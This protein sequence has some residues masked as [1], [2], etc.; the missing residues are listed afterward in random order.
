[1]AAAAAGAIRDRGKPGEPVM[2]A[3]AAVAME[4]SALLILLLLVCGCCSNQ[5][6]DLRL[7]STVAAAAAADVVHMA[8]P[9]QDVGEFDLLLRDWDWESA[10]GLADADGFLENSKL[11]DPVGL[12]TALI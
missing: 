5:A 1:M 10:A 2:A 8:P 11:F 12:P 9:E 4:R 7:L 3:A 6:A